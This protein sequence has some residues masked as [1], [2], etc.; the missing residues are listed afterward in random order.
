[1]VGVQQI[2]VWAPNKKVYFLGISRPRDRSAF[3]G[4]GHEKVI[5]CSEGRTEVGHGRNGLCNRVA[6]APCRGS[7]QL[8][9]P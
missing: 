9:N 6:G 5:D 7:T 1:M 8:S 2:L 3:Y 4:K